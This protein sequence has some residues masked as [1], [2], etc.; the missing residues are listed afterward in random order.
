MTQSEAQL[1]GDLL[2]QL[3]GQGYELVAVPDEAALLANLKLQLGAHNDTSFSDTEFSRILAHLDSGNVFERAGVLRGRF[4]LVR[5]DGSEKSILFLNMHDWCRNRFQVANQIGQEGRRSNRYD[6]TILINGLPLVHIELKRSGM[7]IAE[8]FNQINRYHRDSFSSGSGLF[9]FVQIFVISNGVNTKYYANQRQQSFMQTFFWADE[10][11][12]RISDLSGFA[13]TFLEQCHIAKM[14][15][16]HTVLHQSNKVLMVLRPYQVYAAEAIVEKAQ[17]CRSGGYIW[18]TT[19]S[20]K[21][22]TSFKAAQLI[23]AMP[24]VDKVLFVVD[25]ID[26]DYQT[27]CEFNAYQ[28]GSVDGSSN[29]AELVKHFADPNSKLVVTTIQKLNNA[30]THVRHETVMQEFCDKRVVMIFDECHRSQFGTTHQKIAG[31]F[32]GAQ[33]FGFTGTPIF[34]QNAV[35][36]A[37]D[38]AGDGTMQK[39]TEQLF[40]NLLHK[41][42]ITD[43]I[44][45]GSVLRF[46]VEYWGRLRRRDGSLIDEQV[47]GIDR[48]EFFESDDRIQK[49]CDWII[50][51]HDRK[52]HG[53]TFSSIMAVSSIDVACKYYDQLRVLAREGKHN[54]RIATIFSSPVNEYDPTSDGCLLEEDPE[55]LEAVPANST[56]RAKLDEYIA[57]YK[58]TFGTSFNTSDRNSFYSYYLDIGRRIKGQDKDGAKPSNGIDILLVVNMFLTGF[59]AKK[60]NTMYVDKNLRQHGLIQAFSRTNR[61]LNSQKSQGNIVCFRN[62][63]GAT[64]EAIALF[65]DGDAAAAGTIL[66]EPYEH[67]VDLFNSAI[68]E[69]LSIAP[70]VSSVDALEEEVAKL[71]FIQ[72]FRKMITTMNVLKSFAVFKWADI[73][74]KEQDFA[75]YKSKYLDLYDEVRREQAGD[76]PAS[77]LQEVDF[78]L[79]LIRRDE[80]NVHYILDLLKNAPRSDSRKDKEKRAQIRNTVMNL[81][82]SEVQLRSKRELIEK[83]IEQYWDG[84]MPGTDIR[85]EFDVFWGNERK[86]YLEAVCGQEGL[87]ISSVEKLISQHRFTGGQVPLGN[88]V[89]G[90]MKEKPKILER[91]ERITSATQKIMDVIEI[92]EDV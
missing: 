76:A 78:Q 23:T 47:V 46:S 61:I 27:M 15:C 51:N 4:N 82:G 28:E 90:A 8:A 26:L 17:N 59:D 56:A 44:R 31:H 52:T 34:K 67:Y 81:L 85:S 86:S 45:D 53:R 72:A 49:V 63:K 41:Y 14:I 60:L 68:L 12:K 87:E 42:V 40:G 92:F 24:K 39:T 62:L 37:V 30:I 13:A 79:E 11:N 70:T 84:M 65:A 22:L 77:I 16:R 38:A 50:A 5:D 58:K 36:G 29:T 80:I 69:M 89:I 71:R 20:G 74:M 73:D 10:N 19:G 9:L 35:Q 1:E 33:M 3:Q 64:D 21:T 88:D 66:L 75:D 6:V 48:K 32:R 25:R 18:H 91:R 43:A 83:F 54:L 57:E 7:E 55:S 2:S